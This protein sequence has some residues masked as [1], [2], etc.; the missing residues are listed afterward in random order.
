SLVHLVEPR[1]ATE[2]WPTSLFILLAA[3][4]AVVTW[5]LGQMREAPKTQ[6]ESLPDPAV[7]S[8]LVGLHDF[9][10]AMRRELETSVRWQRTLAHALYGSLFLIG[11]WALVLLARGYT[12]FAELL[13]MAAA[14]TASFVTLNWR[15][16]SVAW[17][18]ARLAGQASQVAEALTQQI[19]R[20]GS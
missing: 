17:R 3:T 11:V 20:L 12:R 13:L 16:Y 9:A 19:R 1:L 2:R 18:R 8:P 6:P 14:L 15:P 7:D 10:H 5:R 4:I